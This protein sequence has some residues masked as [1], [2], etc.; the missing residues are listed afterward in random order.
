M[1]LNIAD[2]MGKEPID[3][4]GQKYKAAD[5]EALVQKRVDARSNARAARVALEK[6]LAV[7]RQ[8]LDDTHDELAVIRDALVAKNRS[9]VEGLAKVGLAPRKRAKSLTG[10]EMVA[11]ADKAKATRKGL[12]APAAVTPAP[13]VATP[14]TPIAPPAPVVVNGTNGSH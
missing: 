6:A 9:D 5:V 10:K 13:A 8:T 7:E 11:K 2:L 14:P 3:A 1:L 12:H 4:D